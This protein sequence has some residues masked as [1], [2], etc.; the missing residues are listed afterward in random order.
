M[1]ITP[2][3]GADAL[4]AGMALVPGT[5][6]ASDLDEYINQTRDYIA[7]RTSTVTPINK[8]GTNATTAAA[9]R[10]NLGITA[11]TVPA[12]G[13]DT[14]Q[15][16]LDAK[17]TRTAAQYNSDFAS[18]DANIN[19]R[20]H[21]D[22]DTMN[23]PLVVNGDLRVPNSSPATSSWQVAYINGDGRISRGSS[24]ERYKKYISTIDPDS[25]G[26]IWPDLTRFQMRHGDPGAWTYGYIAE[27]LAEHDDQRAFVVYADRDGELV[28]DSIDFLPLLMAQ[29]AQLH[30]AVELLVQRVEALEAR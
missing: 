19:A 10:S 22:G 4:A 23:G 30:L 8:G 16:A 11:S 24:S 7:Q 3:P 12:S 28:P 29:N 14:V 17:L 5:G 1:P 13:G 20:I 26:D 6:L 21:R 25:L 2:T 9:A 18:R 15:Q 27:R